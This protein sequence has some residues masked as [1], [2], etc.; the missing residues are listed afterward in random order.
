[1]S[2]TTIT[3]PPQHAQH[4]D[5]DHD[6]LC[7][8]IADHDGLARSMMRAALNDTNRISIVLTAT[9]THEA[10][11]LAGYY[12]PTIII[13]NLE[14]PSIDIA[15]TITK[16]HA[17][18]PH[19]NIITISTNNNNNQPALTALRA[20]A[21][22]HISKNTEPHRLAHQI[23][24]AANGDAIIPQHLIKPLLQ[25][26]QDTPNTGWRP[27]RSRLTCREWEIIDLLA[28]NTTTQQIADQLILTPNTIY[29]HIKSVMRKLGVHSR[30]EA[31]TAAQALRHQEATTTGSLAT[32]G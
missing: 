25:I 16:I 18:S 27:V 4:H 15:Q 2:A 28:T 19:T 26:V 17:S 1:M 23:L 20:G 11:Q 32:A 30:Q 29:S 9:D 14:L 22:G 13:I 31:I 5:H 7:V 8:L 10:T 24:Q 6:R 21:T 12:H 3:R